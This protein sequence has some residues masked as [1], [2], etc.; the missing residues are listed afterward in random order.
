[1]IEV[2][3]SFCDALQYGASFLV[4]AVNPKTSRY[5]RVVMRPNCTDVVTNGIVA[6]FSG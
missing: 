5:D 3:G 2:L 6:A 4:A 1:V